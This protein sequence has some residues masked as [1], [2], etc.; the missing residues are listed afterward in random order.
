M[1]FGLDMMFWKIGNLNTSF[2][3]GR[4]ATHE[5]GHWLNLKHIW[6]DEPACATDDDVIDTPI[7]SNKS[8][9]CNV[10]PKTDLCSLNYPG[11]MFQNYMDYSNDSCLSVYTF[12]QSARIDATLFNQRASLLT[13]NGCSPSNLSNYENVFDKEIKTY[14]N[15]FYKSFNF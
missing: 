5:I 2:N 7:Q 8:I 13:S 14:P 1:E 6:G 3:L 11:I 9:G 4:T 10:F 12:G 15:P